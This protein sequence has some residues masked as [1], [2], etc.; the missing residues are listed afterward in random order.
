MTLQLLNAPLYLLAS[1][2]WIDSGWTAK[3]ELKVTI[4]PRTPDSN[5]AQ[6]YFVS[7]GFTHVACHINLKKTF[8][9]LHNR[10]EN[11]SRGA[12]HSDS[13]CQTF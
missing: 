5:H 1:V 10:E 9:W 11:R 2:E 13:E 3:N 4:K 12:V 6:V 7:F 8:T